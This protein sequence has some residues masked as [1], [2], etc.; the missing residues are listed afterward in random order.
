MPDL[1][2]KEPTVPN[3][4]VRSCDA[5]LPQP[6]ALILFSPALDLTG[7]DPDQKALARRDPMLSLGLFKEVE[8]RWLKGLPLHD[9]RVSALFASHADLPP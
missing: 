2:C 1:F 8:S 9:P 3:D 7:E 4:R 6:K 5:G